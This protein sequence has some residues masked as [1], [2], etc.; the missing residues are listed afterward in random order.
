[1]KL[2]ELYTME[3]LRTK[4]SGAG[5]TFSMEA[6][7]NSMPLTRSIGVWLDT[8]DDIF[9]DFDPRP[10]SERS[11]SDDFLSETRKMFR[12]DPKGRVELKLLIPRKEREKGDE[13]IVGERLRRY[14]KLIE[15]IERKKIASIT[16]R[17]GALSTFGFLLLFIAVLISRMEI[18]SL[19]TDTMLIIFEPAGWFTIW[20]GLDQIF[21]Q[22]PEKKKYL[23][24]FT[25]MAKAE[26]H[27]E[28][29]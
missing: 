17:G 14:F 28:S 22:L 15:K 4:K 8:Y 26:I 6:Q 7:D 23:R 2:G 13:T 29:Y 19:F 11:I 1:M 9:S 18:S 27:F 3:S 10:Y 24:F 20:F 5:Y 25:K 12:E 16:K 21:Y